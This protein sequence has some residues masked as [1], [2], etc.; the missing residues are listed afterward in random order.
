MDDV[1][2]VV[3]PDNAPMVAKMLCMP[4]PVFASIFETFGME[5][6]M[7]TGYDYLRTAGLACVATPSSTRGILP[8]R[9]HGYNTTAVDTAGNTQGCI[10]KVLMRR[11][12]S[13]N[14][15]RDCSFLSFPE[16]VH[17]SHLLVESTSSTD[18]AD[19]RRKEKTTRTRV[20]LRL[21]T[22][23]MLVFPVDNLTGYTALTSD[24]RVLLESVRG[25]AEFLASAFPLACTKA[26]VG[27]KRL[28]WRRK[29]D[30]QKEI[31][32]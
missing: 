25:N 23:F 16:R 10:L 3:P 28:M 11:R 14:M 31:S 32:E 9:N 22:R 15:I 4:M 7:I 24:V 20:S 6:Q 27:C 29:H 18:I 1:G 21:G 5:L 17:S 30:I 12:L 19:Q 26:R 13:T 8:F 2:T